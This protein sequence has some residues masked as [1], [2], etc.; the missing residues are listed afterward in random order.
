VAL[1]INLPEGERRVEH[2][3]DYWVNTLIHTGDFEQPWEVD[4]EVLYAGDS[5]AHVLETLATRKR[6]D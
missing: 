6:E 4:T 3:E 2:V 1:W 5:W